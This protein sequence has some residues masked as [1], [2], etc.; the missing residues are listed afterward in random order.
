MSD[1]R[2]TRSLKQWLVAALLTITTYAFGILPERRQIEA[3]ETQVHGLYDTTNRDERLTARGLGLMKAQRLAE[4]DVEHIAGIKIVP[5]SAHLLKMLDLESERLGLSVVSVSPD[6]T[7]TSLPGGKRRSPLIEERFHID[8]Q[9]R[10]EPILAFLSELTNAEMLLGVQS[11]SLSTTDRGQEG[12]PQLL[13]TL[14][15]SAYH[16]DSRWK[17]YLDDS[18]TSL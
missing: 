5:A 3:V 8:V 1:V 14:V 2:P 18:G 7:Q 10:F 12:P 17:E 9:G 13:A 4:N 6:A 15:V 16:L 11:I